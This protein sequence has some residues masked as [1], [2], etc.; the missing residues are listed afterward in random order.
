MQRRRHS[1]TTHFDRHFTFTYVAMAIPDATPTRGDRVQHDIWLE[2]GL[3]SVSTID[4]DK[5]EYRAASEYALLH[6]ARFAH[7]NPRW[8][9][10]QQQLETLHGGTQRSRPRIDR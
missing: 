7:R 5:N 8:H 9:F 4:V 6:L 3:S 10:H 1:P 2:H